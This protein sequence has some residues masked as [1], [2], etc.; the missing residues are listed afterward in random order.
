MASRASAACRERLATTA[1]HLAWGVF[2]CLSCCDPIHAGYWRLQ[3]CAGCTRCW[4]AI[5]NRT[6]PDSVWKRTAA[7]A[8]NLIWDLFGCLGLSHPF[9][10]RYWRRSARAGSLWCCRCRNASRAMD[11]TDWQLCTTFS[12]ITC[13][14]PS[15]LPT[16]MCQPLIRLIHASPL[17]HSRMIP[18]IFPLILRFRESILKVFRRPMR[19]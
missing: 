17:V 11:S 6:T 9:Y 1:A 15:P 16:C 7:A 18:L 8:A 2:A 3:A 10:T 13:H 4:R 5:A 19:G 12:T 14:M